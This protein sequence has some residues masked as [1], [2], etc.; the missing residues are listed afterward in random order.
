[1][2]AR[3]EKLRHE[4]IEDGDLLVVQLRP[5]GRASSGELVI[6]KIGEERL[7]RPLVQK[8]GTKALMSDGPSGGDHGRREGNAEGG[9][10]INAIL[11]PEK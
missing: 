1:L 3:G 5:K 4:G 6:G 7:R 2:R 11:R 8:N 9:G 10:G